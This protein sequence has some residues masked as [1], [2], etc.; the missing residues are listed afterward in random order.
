MSA[1]VILKLF[2][3]EMKKT[4][5]SRLVVELPFLLNLLNKFNT[6]GAQMVESIYHITLKWHHIFGMNIFKIL[7]VS[8]YATLL[9]TLFQ[10]VTRYINN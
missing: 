9:W 5:N 4:D 7:S 1:H 10:N 6:T 3:N 2:I 8:M